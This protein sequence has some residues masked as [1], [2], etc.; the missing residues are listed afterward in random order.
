MILLV[1]TAISVSHRRRPRP[2]EAIHRG[3][4]AEGS[5]PCCERQLK[6]ACAAWAR[7]GRTG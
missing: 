7:L 5:G 2:A 6:N 1:D 4:G 3:E